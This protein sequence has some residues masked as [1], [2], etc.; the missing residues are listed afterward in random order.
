MM[1]PVMPSRDN[2]PNAVSRS[3]T[4]NAGQRLLL[5]LYALA[6]RYGLFETSWGRWSFEWAYEAY[7]TWLEAADVEVL[8]SFVEPGTLVIDVGANVGFFTTRFARWVSPP[9][10]VIAI[11]P[12]AANLKR[13]KEALG[14]QGVADRVEIVAAAATTAVG[15]VFV[16]VNPD[17]PGDHRLAAD[18]EM[19]DG[20]TLDGVVA[21]RAWAPVSLIKIDVQGAESAVIAGAREVLRRFR[22]ALYVE[23]DDRNLR[24]FGSS[25]ADLLDVLANLGYQ[26]CRSSAGR[27]VPLDRREL[28]ARA[29]AAY[30]D[31]LF[32]S[33]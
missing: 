27:A 16:A 12:E 26:P 3:G 5:R 19:V 18:G 32:L 4:R 25:A 29:A 1:T 20:V 22:P 24:E 13:L 9:G 11:E 10:R 2:R 30:I 23:L 33:G 31:V 17:H 14:D 6:R 15:P 7:K 28:L 8:Q 21:E